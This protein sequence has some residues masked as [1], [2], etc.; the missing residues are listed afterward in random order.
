MSM[1]VRTKSGVTNHN[2]ID[3]IDLPMYCVRDGPGSFMIG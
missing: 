2:T 3:V 1:N